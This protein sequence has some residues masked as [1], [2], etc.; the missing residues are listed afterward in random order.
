MDGGGCDGA[1][2]WRGGGSTAGFAC[3]AG[4]DLETVGISSSKSLNVTDDPYITAARPKAFCLNLSTCLASHDLFF[5][6]N[7]LVCFSFS[8]SSKNSLITPAPFNTACL[9]R[10]E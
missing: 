7:I 8:T 4:G 1:T 2:T 10:R 3:G 6:Y 5:S 9:E